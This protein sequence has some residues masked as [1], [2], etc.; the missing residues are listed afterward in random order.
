VNVPLVVAGGLALLGAAVHGTGGH[1]LIV[2]RLRTDTLPSTLFG[3][4]TATRVMV[5]V[6]WHLVT[7]T[8]AVT[9][10][11]LL[12]CAGSAPGAHCSGT[13][14]VIAALFAAFAVVSL[15]HAI[16][17]GN[18]RILSRHPAPT[19]FVAIAVLAWVGSG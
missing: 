7:V 4:P 18:A 3:G 10:A 17:S 2:R 8:F 5:W 19:A 6:S 13:G 12:S 14:R 1:L 15:G 11:S 16:A 9:G